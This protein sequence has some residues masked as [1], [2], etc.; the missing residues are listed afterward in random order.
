MRY[1][2]HALA[3]GIAR[4]RAGHFIEA[5][6]VYESLLSLSMDPKI[7]AV[8][9]AN[10]SELHTH[11]NRWPEARMAAEEAL[12]IEPQNGVAITTIVRCDRM[13]GHA[14][15]ALD[16]LLGWPSYSLPP[17]LIHE[18]ALCYEALGEYT[19]AYHS[20]R[21]ANRRSSFDDLDVD[22][23]L[24]TRYIE[25]MLV[26]H[27]A[28]DLD[29][30]HPAPPM[31]RPSPLFIVGFNSSGG[32]EL[33][34]L[35][36]Q[37]PAYAWTGNTAAMDAARTALNGRDLEPMSHLRPKHIQQAR[38]AYF[39]A[40]S[41]K[42]TPDQRVVD[43]VPLNVL[44]LPLIH[45]LFPESC[46]IRMVRHPVETVFQAFRTVHPVNAVTC[47]LDSMSRCAQF[48]LAVQ[49]MGDHYRDV[50][51]IPMSEITYEEF[52]L[53]P[54]RYAAAITENLGT[55]WTEL[56]GHEPAS[57][58]D[59]WPLYRKVIAPWTRDLISLAERSGYPAK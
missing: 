38:E 39:Q 32:Q 41:K 33:A 50:L 1:L 48:F 51:K 44:S 9:L 26:T 12:Q 22:R 23:T 3:H 19:K 8:A 18:M 6:S 46:I 24:V 20:F 56:P 27:Q 43:S 37:H 36:N 2:E 58:R 30:A 10:L 16:R 13:Q 53:C 29:G 42:V 52:T 49:A 5:R 28:L 15:K 31:D 11:A 47:H 59:H 14:Q 57:P 45:R 40:T 7:C 55:G 54:Q 35:I 25:K 34:E 4:H 17:G 21:E